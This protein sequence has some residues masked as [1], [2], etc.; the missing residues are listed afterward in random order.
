MY[1][2]TDKNYVYVKKWIRTKHAILFRLSNK[3]VQVC[4]LDSTELILRSDTKQITYVN[5]KNERK[6]YP[7]NTYRK[8]FEVLKRRRKS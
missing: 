2:I 8:C 6:N 7:L 5:K 1:N 4:F 3:I